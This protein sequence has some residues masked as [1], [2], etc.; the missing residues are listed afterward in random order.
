MSPKSGVSRVFRNVSEDIRSLSEGVP[1]ARR[2]HWI[3]GISV[4][5]QLYKRVPWIFKGASG[6]FQVISNNF[7]G[8]PERSKTFPEI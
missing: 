1:F 3:T 2:F 8:F 4:A 6:A 5:L 7:R